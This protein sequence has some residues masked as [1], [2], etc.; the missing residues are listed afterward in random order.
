MGRKV[1]PRTL[2]KGA[3]SRPRAPSTNDRIQRLAIGQALSLSTNENGIRAAAAIISR[4]TGRQFTI[5]DGP[6]GRVLTRRG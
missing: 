6:T 4:N 2:P 3:I 5:D 1:K